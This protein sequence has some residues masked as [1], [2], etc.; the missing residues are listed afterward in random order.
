MED[1]RSAADPARRRHRAPIWA[2]AAVLAV[3][4]LVVGV[5][6]VTR[7]DDDGVRT[8]TSTS[9]STTA[10][11]TTSSS[12]TSGGTTTSGSATT[13]PG[14]GGLSSDE[15]SSVVWP[16][17]TGET[18]YG[19]AASAARGF[20]VDLVGFTDPVVGD[21]QQGDAR[22][23]EVEVRATADG[24][25]TTV[26]VRRMSDDR[27]YVI[28]ATTADIQPSYPIAGTAI[29]TPL[30][31]TGRARAFEGTV[32]VAVYGRGATEPLGEGFV[33]GSGGPDL[34]AFSG[35]IA[36]RNPV[37]GWGVVLFTVASAEDGRISAAVAIPVG[38]IGGD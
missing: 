3:V 27:W 2:L 19:S 34:G 33:T 17:P 26:L 24:P 23:G 22:S 38:F 20:A 29:D 37:G 18:A 14:I 21:F 32:R 10:V 15:A 5:L 12:A 25:A 31:V 11:T 30:E 16:S 13:A 9:S 36:W 6:L 7:D 28:G 1:T 35:Q 4:A 8:V